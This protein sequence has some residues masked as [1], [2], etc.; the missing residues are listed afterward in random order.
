VGFFLLPATKGMKKAM[1]INFVSAAMLSLAVAAFMYSLTEL[2][3]RNADTNMAIV[4]SGIAIAIVV[5]VLFL[6]HESRTPFPLLDT[7]IL[8][9]KEFAFVNALSFFNGA[10]IFGA[11]TF[12]PTYVKAAYGMGTGDSTTMLTARATTMVIV[13]ALA[14]MLLMRTGYRKPI[15]AGLLSIAV[16]LVVMSMGVH[17]AQIAGLHLSNLLW[18]TILVALT[19]GTFAMIG[20]AANNASLDLAPDRIAA[21][22]GLR[23][24]FMALGGAIGS[25]FVVLAA[26]RASSEGAGVRTRFCRPSRSVLLHLSAGVRHPRKGP[27]SH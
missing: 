23:G 18:M 10:I 6:R 15:A 2:G 14:S 21:I 25:A 4:V 12:I 17:N 24:M 8:K 5:A 3:R 13:S 27:S 9:R 7:D 20:P 1:N 19:G 22:V 16:V 26:S 11:F